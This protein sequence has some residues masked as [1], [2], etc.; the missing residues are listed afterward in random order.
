ML[1]GRSMS[2][3]VP[4][5]DG[6]SGAA[7]PLGEVAKDVFDS[8]A[9]NLRPRP[10]G[11]RI[12]L[13]LGFDGLTWTRKNG[14]VRWILRCVDTKDKHNDPQYAQEGCTYAGTDKNAGVQQVALVHL[15]KTAGPSG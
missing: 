6:I 9:S 4:S 7:R 2:M 13:W 10:L 3:A 15:P 11:R 1:R 8:V 14:L 12:R 5:R